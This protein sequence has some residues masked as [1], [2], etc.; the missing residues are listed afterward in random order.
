MSGAKGAPESDDARGRILGRIRDALRDRT[1]VAHPGDFGGWRPEGALDPDPIRAFAEVFTAA[2]GEVVELAS[3]SE[4]R[5]WLADFAQAFESASVGATVPIDLRPE[6][7]VASAEE[8]PLGVG[9][10]RCAV[11]ETGS[12]VLDAR[13]GRRTQLLPPT[14]MVWL[15]AA[16]VHATLRDALR[17]LGDDL[18]SALG[19]H[20]GPSKSA[21]IGQILVRGVHGPGRLV[22]AILR[23]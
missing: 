12:L 4:A 21:D 7:P 18:P 19:L 10:A 5:R 11:A 9:M 20:S 2:G 16:D 14:H 3:M 13:D 8:A 6:R 22:V 15:R 23:A 1:A 17:A